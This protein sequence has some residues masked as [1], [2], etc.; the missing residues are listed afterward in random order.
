MET[1]LERIANGIRRLSSGIPSVPGYADFDDEDDD[2]EESDPE[3]QNCAAVELGTPHAKEAF[4]TLETRAERLLE[5]VGDPWLCTAYPTLRSDM[6][7]TLWSIWEGEEDDDP[8][9]EAIRKAPQ[10]TGISL[11]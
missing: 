5:F 6:S 8:L 1:D 9:M 3:D 11:V 2:E 4:E 10:K 7:F